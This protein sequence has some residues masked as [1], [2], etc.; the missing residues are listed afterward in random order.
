MPLIKLE[1]LETPKLFGGWGLKHIHCFSKALAAKV[2]WR[3]ITTTSL[4]I[5]VVT[6]NTFA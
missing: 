2:G 5:K 6:Q 4:W 3:L 1:T